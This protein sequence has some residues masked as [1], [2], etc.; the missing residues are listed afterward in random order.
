MPKK[1]E[2]NNFE[3][4]LQKLNHL[5]EKMES[6]DS[7]LDAAIAHFKEGMGLL[8]QCQA[9]LAAAEQTVKILME[10]AGKSSLKSF[11]E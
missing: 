8:Q 5:I 4:S 1:S 11:E 6:D 10:T 2:Q 7:N 9:Q 3:K